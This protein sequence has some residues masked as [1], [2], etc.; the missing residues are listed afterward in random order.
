[1]EQKSR[2]IPYNATIEEV[3]TALESINVKGFGDI[4]VM[5]DHNGHGDV[6]GGRRWF[7]TTQ[8]NVSTIKGKVNNLKGTKSYIHV[9]KTEE[10]RFI[11]GQFR[12]SLDGDWS[13]PIPAQASPLEVEFALKKKKSSC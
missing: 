10:R 6:N 1:M 13:D 3:K 7:I 9:T 4:Q 8:N 11:Q 2:P 12:L 5:Q